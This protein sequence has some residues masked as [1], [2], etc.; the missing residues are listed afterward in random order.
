MMMTRPSL[1]YRERGMTLMEAMIAMAVFTIGALGLLR[2]MISGSEGTGV[3]THVTAATLLARNRLD[4]L[5]QL[6]Y[7]HA[8]LAPDSAT[9]PADDHVEPGNRNLGANGGLLGPHNTATG[10]AG[11]ADGNFWRTWSVVENNEHT[12]KTI[13]VKVTWMDNAA[14]G[15]RMERAVSVLG[16]KYK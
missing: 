14:G 4:M 3:S 16:G 13:T 6:P 8:D 10:A 11:D 9:D 5:M 15:S 1:R 12:F 2:L 7:D